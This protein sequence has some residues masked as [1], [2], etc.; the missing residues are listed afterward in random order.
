MF[1]TTTTEVIAE[2]HKL[3]AAHPNFTYRPIKGDSCSYL[4]DRINPHGCIIG[5]ALTALGCPREALLEHEGSGVGVMLPATVLSRSWA[6]ANGC[7]PQVAIIGTAHESKWLQY[8][9]SGQDSG[10]SWREAI[11]SANELEPQ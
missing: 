5:A 3:A 7:P 10:M 2:V 6:S 11:Q 4:P 9:Q 1:T 8:V